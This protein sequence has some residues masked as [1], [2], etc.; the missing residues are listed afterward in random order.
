[1]LS[2]SYLNLPEKYI[3]DKNDFFSSGIVEASKIR[4]L[5][6]VCQRIFVTNS[7]NVNLFLL[8]DKDIYRIDIFSDKRLISRIYYLPKQFRLDFYDG[9]DP[10]NPMF[11]WKSKKC[12]YKNVPHSLEV[13]KV[14]S[15]FL[16]IISIL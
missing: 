3:E 9:N 16:P 6:N 12:V 8:G 11:M 5:C 7:K 4:N 2:L 15:L 14:E 13:M 1:M 10:F